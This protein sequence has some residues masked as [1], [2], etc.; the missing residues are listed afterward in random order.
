MTTYFSLRK[1]LIAVFGLLLI[2]TAS[3]EGIFAVHISRK[4]VIEK[5]ES[6]LKDKA[7]AAADIIDGR[8]AALFQFVEGVSRFS[9]LRDSSLSF[10]NRAA[11]LDKEAEN[12]AQ[13]QYFGICD[14]NGTRYEADGRRIAMSDRQWFQAALKGSNF[15]SEPL[16]SRVTG[17]MQIIIAVPIKD[18]G[19]TIVGVL[20][21][22]VAG[23]LLSHYISDITIGQTGVSSKRRKTAR[24]KQKQT[25]PMRA[26][27]NSSGRRWQRQSLQ[28]AI[29]RGTEKWKSPRLQKSA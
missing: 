27:Q 5:V 24:K 21:A 26:W 13:I 12:N 8:I 6:H 7:V 23:E 10:V 4:A 15:I 22:A 14:V 18:D 19:N 29:F 20:S 1:K 16:R 28:S 17:K 3:V 2:I 9:Y 25:A 11:L